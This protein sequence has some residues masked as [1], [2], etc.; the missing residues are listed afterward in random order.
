[1]TF[2][3]DTEVTALTRLRSVLALYALRCR[4]AALAVGPLACSSALAPPP[5]PAAAPVAEVVLAVAAPPAPPPCSPGPPVCDPGAKDA[6]LVCVDGVETPRAC[7]G[8]AGCAV[9]NGVTSCD[10]S[11][12]AAGEAC[13]KDGAFACS[14]T[15]SDLLVCHAGRFEWRSRCAGP[16]ACR[17]WGESARCDASVANEG[18]A[19]P[20]ETDLA[21]TTDGRQLECGGGRFAVDPDAKPALGKPCTTQGGRLFATDDGE[22]YEAVRRAVRPAERTLEHDRAECDQGKAFGCEQLAQHLDMI[23]ERQGEAMG[24]YQHACDGGMRSACD[25]VVERLVAGHGTPKD[26]PR[27]LAIVKARCDRDHTPTRVDCV[28]LAFLYEHELATPEKVA[29]ARK[30]YERACTK[31]NVMECRLFAFMLAQG[32][33]GPKDLSRAIKLLTSECD[34]GI[35]DTCEPLGEGLL[36]RKDLH[37]AATAFRRACRFDV[38]LGCTKLGIMFEHGQGVARDT[39]RAS[40]LFRQACGAGESTACEEL[41]ELSSHP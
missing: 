8:P 9:E 15:K 4:F 29:L 16:E 11:L 39:V 32:K 5:P 7:H 36:E 22:Q 35:V 18:D 19:C 26:V 13:F 6:E 33:G 10:R 37:E 12:A 28:P 41:K 27:A 21:C 14:S 20:Y 38:P 23:P 3:G 17:A 34:I 31:D 25:E 24:L 2:G 40:L 1:M 30:M